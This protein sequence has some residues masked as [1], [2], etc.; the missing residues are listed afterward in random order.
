M[1]VG[2]QRVLVRGLWVVELSVMVAVCA[3]CGGWTERVGWG[4]M[5]T[6]DLRIR[7][8]LRMNPLLFPPAPVSRTSI[9]G[10]ARPW[11]IGRAHHCERAG[12]RGSRAETAAH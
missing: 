9:S 1:N 10:T 2:G 6:G 4:R 11:T 8:W 5:A 12:I 7:F 3:A